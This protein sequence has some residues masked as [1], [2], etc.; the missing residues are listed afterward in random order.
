V[1][2]R[3]AFVL[4]HAQRSFRT[5]GHGRLI[6]RISRSKR[7][8][9]RAFFASVC[10]RSPNSS[11]SLRVMPRFFAM[12]SADWNWV[13][14]GV[15]RPLGRLEEAGAVQDVRTPSRR[16]SSPRRRTRAMSNLPGFHQ[17]RNEVIRLLPGAALCVDGRASPRSS[18]PPRLSHAWRATLFDCSPG[19]RHAPTDDLLGLIVGSMP[20][21]SHTRAARCRGNVAG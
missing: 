19:L 9:S 16:G 15:P 11:V 4:R 14:R 17:C 21:F 18:H 6:G 3:N 20:A 2:S 13:G 7:P 1:L 5:V 12:R 10:E 8:S